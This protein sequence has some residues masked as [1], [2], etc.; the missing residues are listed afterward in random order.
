[1]LWIVLG[2]DAVLLIVILSWPTMRDL[3]RFGP[4]HPDDLVLCLGV[5]IATLLVLEL[6]KK[7]FRRALRA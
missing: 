3:F 2:I 4:L 1:V 6:L 7:P 5:G